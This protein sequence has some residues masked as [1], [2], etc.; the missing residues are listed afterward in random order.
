[1]DED[2]PVKLFPDYEYLRFFTKLWLRERK[3]AVP[4]SRRMT[5]S[6]TCIALALWDV[7]FHPGR[8]W[9]FV[10][11]K[12]DDSKELVARAEFIYQ[13]IP[14]NKIPREL[15]PPIKGG[16]MKLSPPK[17]ELDF[18][19]DS[20][21]SHI[22][23]FPMGAD[24]LRQFTFSGIFGD[25]SGFWPDAENF[26]AGAKPTTDGG[27]RMVMV[28]SRAPGFFKK[29][30]FD[31]INLKGNNFAETP[32]VPPKFPMQG[33]ELWK[34]PKNGF[35]V[36][37]LH[38][39]AHPDKRDPSFK[40]ALKDSLPVHQ[41]LREY[42]KNW[43]TFA[44]MPVYPNYRADLHTK[45]VPNVPHLGLPL[46]FGWDFGLCYDAATEV[47]TS[48]GWKY[49]KDIDLTIDKVASMD[50]STHKA[51]FVTPT[52]KIAQEYTGDLYYC[53]GQNL[54]FAITPDHII[55]H[56]TETGKFERAYAKELLEKPGH[57][58]IRVVADFTEGQECSVHNLAPLTE[59]ALL[60]F[61]LSD[62]T[63]DKSKMTIV[64]LKPN[65][66]LATVIA[67]T[68]W[69]FKKHS[70]G[71][72]LNNTTMATM[73]HAYGLQKS[74]RIPGHIMQGTRA[75]QLAFIKAYTAGDGHKR[76]RNNGAEEHTIF[77]CSQYMAD[78][79]QALAAL[80][81]WNSSI[82][83]IKPTTSYYKEEQRWITNTGG[84]T[85]TFKKVRDYIDLRSYKHIRKPYKG[86][87]YCLTV[88]HGMLYVRRGG[89]PHWNGNSPACVVAQL[90]GTSL[91][92]LKEWTAKNE[93]IRTFAPTVM[94]EVAGMF[95]AWNDPHKDHHHFIDPAGF[96]RSQVDAR[97]CAQEMQEHANIPNINPGPVTWEKRRASVEHFLLSLSKDG[98]GLEMNFTECPTLIEGFA[99]GYRYADSTSDIESARPQAIKDHYSHVAD[100]FQYLCYGARENLD[101]KN[102]TISIPK[103][104][105][106]FAPSTVTTTQGNQY[107]RT[108]K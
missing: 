101:T 2:N 58:K 72:T 80:V 89:R 79:F 104:S 103:P 77:T 63:S 13:K 95:P 67:E 43:Q 49:F 4:K 69:N 8:E 94:A 27:G 25:E 28:S 1:V 44:G 16:K 30:C 61:Y 102:Q 76:T 75:M 32:P 81:G 73:F 29:L 37:D 86:R 57:R 6:W 62:G 71:Y 18:G 50:P 7:L 87:I 59:A 92:V 24:Q 85:I 3:I 51:T 17:F 47:L 48:T 107:G 68:G 97:T 78:D 82:R 91:K 42:E 45:E 52:H 55:P 20:V 99:G 93:S 96:A 74:R 84:Y 35:V 70:Q 56:W 90:Q 40:A 10:S 88:P 23:G 105:Y 53:E 100:A 22:A 60:G 15:L 54:N 106:S 39:T 36:M 26:Y 11:K 46:L 34:N 98:A 31:K 108:I 38:Y 33:V 9:A 12:E 66:P 64:Q 5:M 83:V 65:D 21:A 14:P 41:Y 19:K